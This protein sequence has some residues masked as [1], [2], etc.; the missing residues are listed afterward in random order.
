MLSMVI[1]TKSSNRLER[2][3]DDWM[4]PLHPDLR[5]M[6]LVTTIG[7]E[8]CHRRGRETTLLVVQIGDLADTDPMLAE[9]APDADLRYVAVGIVEAERFS[10]RTVR[11]DDGLF[12]G[13]TRDGNSFAFD[14]VVMDSYRGDHQSRL[15]W[16]TEAADWPPGLDLPPL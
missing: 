12:R 4:I 15:R 16:V 11:G 3:P 5:D 13:T 14:D 8:P 1:D 2:Q 10:Y 9:L 6:K 7:C